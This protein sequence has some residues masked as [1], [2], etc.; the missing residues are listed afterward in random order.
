M[1]SPYADVPCS[2]ASNPAISSSAVTLSPTVESIALN[3]R[4]DVPY[5]QAPIAKIPIYCGRNNVA[6]PP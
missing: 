2:V 4:K 6:P 1:K 5:A 3:T